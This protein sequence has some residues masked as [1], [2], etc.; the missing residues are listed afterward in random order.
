MLAKMKRRGLA[1]FVAMVMVLGML[2]T[3]ALADEL[4]TAAPGTEIVDVTIPA[5]DQTEETEAS[6]VVVVEE[7]ETSDA[8]QAEESE[9]SDA[10]Q[11]EETETSDA[12]QAEET[13]GKPETVIEEPQVPMTAA[14]A[15][16]DAVIET[17]T[18]DGAVITVSGL[19]PQGAYVTAEPV[20]VTLEDLTVLAAYDITIYDAEGNV[21]QPDE[22][23][24][25]DIQT[26]ILADAGEVEIYHMEDA[27]AEPEYVETVTADSVATFSAESF[28]V[29]VIAKNHED[30]SLHGIGQTA[31]LDGSGRLSW[32]HQWSSS[33][34]DVATVKGNGDD[35]T[36]TAV[37]AGTV[38][39]T[40]K[41]TNGIYPFHHTETFN[42]TV[43]AATGQDL[44][45]V[46]K[47]WGGHYYLDANVYL[48]Y[49]NT[50]PQNIQKP[51]DTE[52]F[53]PRGDNTPYFTVRVDMTELLAKANVGIEIK[54]N[55]Y[56]Y[57]SYQTSS[58]S[59]SALEQAEAL[60]QDIL[61][62]MSQADQK[63]FT[64]LFYNNYIGYVLKVEDSGGH[65][66]G[67]YKVDPAYATEVYVENQLVASA[68]QNA[69]KAFND[70]PG[71]L[72]EKYDVTWTESGV[73][74]TYTQDGR[75]YEIT[76]DQ[77][78]STDHQADG[79]I[80]YTEKTHEFYVARF[81]YSVK[82]VTPATVSFTLKKVDS[83]T[84]TGL[85]DAQFTV[86]TDEGCTKV[87]TNVG[88]NGVVTTGKDGTVEVKLPVGQIYYM[89]ET[90][91]P[92]GYQQ[93]KKTVYQ[94]DAS[95][96]E[97]VNTDS[98]WEKF[99]ESIFGKGNAAGKCGCFE[100]RTLTVENTK[101]PQTGILKIQKTFEA[102]TAEDLAAVTSAGLFH[103]DVTDANGNAVLSNLTTA[104]TA[105][106]IL[107]GVESD[108]TG[109]TVTY[110][111]TLQLP[112][113]MYTVTEDYSDALTWYNVSASGEAAQTAN[114]QSAF[115]SWVSYT[116]RYFKLETVTQGAVELTKNVELPDGVELP[117][118]YSVQLILTSDGNKLGSVTFDKSDLQSGSASRTVAVDAGTYTN[119]RI[120]EVIITDDAGFR[121]DYEHSAQGTGILADLTVAA[122]QVTDLAVTNT[123]TSKWQPM[124]QEG[125]L[126][127]TK[128]VALPE[129]VSLPD[130]YQVTLT[131]TEN[132]VTVGK[133]TFY[134]YNLT[135]GSASFDIYG[136]SAG[137]HT[138]VVYE[139]VE[140]ASINMD[141]NTSKLVIDGVY[142]D[143]EADGTL[144]SRTVD[145]KA[146][147]VN[148]ELV[149]TNTYT[150]SA[151]Q[152][153]PQQGMLTVTKNVVLPEGVS[154]PEDYQVT[155]TVTE[156]GITVGQKTFYAYNFLE[157]SASFDIYGVSAGEH[158][159]VVY[160][161]VESASIDMSTNPSKLVIDGVYYDMK[162]DGTLVS[163]TVEVKANQVNKD[164]VVTNT[165]TESEKQ[166]TV[167]KPNVTITKTA[168]VSSVTVGG[169]IT[170]TI[171]ATNT[172]DADATDVKITDTLPTGVTYVSSSDG[173]SLTNGTVTWEIGTLASN[174]SKSVTVT[175]TA[176]QTGTA[177][178]TAYIDYTENGGDP[179]PS[180]AVTTSVTSGGGTTPTDPTPGTSDDGDDDDDDRGNGGGG[181]VNIPDGNVPQGSQTDDGVTDI[182]GNDVPLGDTPSVPVTGAEDPVEI[183]DDGVPMGNLPQT[184][185]MATPA[186]PTVTLGALAMSASLVAA[187]LAITISRKREEDFLD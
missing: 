88:N 7:T 145:V 114:V 13:A 156:N 29:Y 39:I 36:V 184:G 147:Q 149:V 130:D 165:Y 150:K 28:S 40:H 177:V 95:G 53:G 85:A 152:P 155:L 139:S 169:S 128:N 170:Y 80:D 49:S 123:Y 60:W 2:P 16:E 15:L 81:Y 99:W 116:N 51:F 79:T 113:G 62:C 37:S 127:V 157:G 93:D 162:A 32:D 133:K 55:D 42:V 103:L 92:D 168:N 100:D 17:K 153:V 175:V 27:S 97:N 77:R 58:Y 48:Y 56:W 151:E 134:A 59:G 86:Y 68:F 120:D 131:V 167:S 69:P 65:I 107:T 5:D 44:K 43:K 89:K 143:M 166:P 112:L 1:L 174:A 23:V 54:A 148:K 30:I 87:A 119:V 25:V 84:K 138:Y 20:E 19:L 12:E 109:N 71:M 34:P 72:A 176:D 38:K 4:E 160:E 159:Y 104:S 164:L 98:W 26:P 105:D 146:N 18:E 111:W 47:G 124:P 67:I 96:K 172:G 45:G 181:T 91:A 178:N 132:G 144:V 142:Y 14:P 101:L 76:L 118:D 10:E 83:E 57:I 63:K 22:S 180:T 74:G 129:G 3:A 78:S 64:D 173:G 90:D 11:A 154:L 108:Q 110:T 6:D 33:N 135:T 41:Y 52:D 183:T 115:A 158:T 24:D 179:I 171:T 186:N 61:S 117:D 163:R 137:E 8:E 140:S 35:A 94:L 187:G 125:T 121:E 46:E 136:V 73:K 161:T 122:G 102:E 82:D 66:D 75:T 70:I 50:L 9:T 126:T 141:T 106:E 182:G 21:W 31:T 185:T